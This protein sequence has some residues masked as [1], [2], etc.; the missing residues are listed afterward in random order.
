M[1]YYNRVWVVNKIPGNDEFRQKPKICETRIRRESPRIPSAALCQLPEQLPAAE[2]PLQ[3]PPNN[4]KHVHYGHKEVKR[5]LENACKQLE[6]V[7]RERFIMEQKARIEA[8]KK[9][10]SLPDIEH[11]QWYDFSKYPTKYRNCK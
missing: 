10:I 2:F 11:I 3:N 6:L 9:G 4:W 5:T 8:C 7:E 1:E